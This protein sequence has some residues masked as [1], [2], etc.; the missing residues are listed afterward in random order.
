MGALV[1]IL[2]IVLGNYL[3]ARFGENAHARE[4]GTL[5][6]TGRHVPKDATGT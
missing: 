4:G 6:G 1:T 3:W 5:W 2:G